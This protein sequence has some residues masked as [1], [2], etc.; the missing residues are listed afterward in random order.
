MRYDSYGFR[1][2]GSRFLI[3]LAIIMFLLFVTAGGLLA[4][5]YKHLGNLLK[6]ISL[7]RTQYLHPV[8]SSTLVEGAV[9]GL[10]ESLDDPYSVYYDA[11]TFAQLQEQI[12]G[13][14]GG[15]GILVGIK[16]DY[17]TVVRSYRGTPAQREGI[18]DGDVIT[19]IDDKDAK[20]IDLETAVGLM[21]GPVGTKISLTIAPSG[22]GAPREVELTREEISVPTVEGKIIP[23]DVYGAKDIAYMTIS[24]FT[25][26]TPGEVSE[27]LERFKKEGMRGL[28]LDLRDN[29]GGELHSAVKVAD[30]FVPKGPVVFIDYRAGKDEEFKAD[31]NYLRIPLVLLVNEGSASAAEILAGAVKDTKVGTLVGE[32]TFGKGI[33]QTVFQLENGTGLKLTTARYLTP[34]KKDIHKKGISPDVEIIQDPGARPDRQLEKAVQIVQEKLAS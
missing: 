20:G 30:N 21:R 22:T 2:R 11:K 25:E 17:L 29:P 26:N 18:K 12:R 31:N 1:P 32:K 27:H 34:A 24:Q 4:S 28:I 33:V 13:S 8:P 14:F 10:V 6:V 19:K 5:N 3:I 9:K 7:V 23:E 16:D 15:L